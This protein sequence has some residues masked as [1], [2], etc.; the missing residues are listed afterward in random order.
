MKGMEEFCRQV[1]VLVG[2]KDLAVTFA[3]PQLEAH[4]VIAAFEHSTADEH[5]YSVD[6]GLGC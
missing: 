3:D 6:D 5:G 4:R 2:Q 1:V